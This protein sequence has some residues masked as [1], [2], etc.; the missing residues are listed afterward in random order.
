MIKGFFAF[1]LLLHSTQLYSMTGS[2]EEKKTI[3][4]WGIKE[5]LFEVSFPLGFKSFGPITPERLQQ[6]MFEKLQNIPVENAVVK[7]LFLTWRKFFNTNCKTS[8]ALPKT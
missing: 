8:L 4:L 3:I 1:I 2:S 6:K 5:V 7:F